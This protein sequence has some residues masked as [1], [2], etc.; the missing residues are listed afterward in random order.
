MTPEPEVRATRYE[1]SCVS[2]DHPDAPVWTI[3]VEYRG[4]DRWAVLERGA[5]LDADGNRSWGSNWENG[6]EPVTDE[7]LAACRKAHEE[8]LNAHR[9][10]LETALDI[11]RKRAPQLTIGRVTVQQVLADST[12]AGQ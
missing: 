11:A 12:E 1:V 10:D 9:F 3:T 2:E 7:E 6:R 4:N 5:Y 8:W